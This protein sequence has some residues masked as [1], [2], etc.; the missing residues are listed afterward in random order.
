MLTLK[1]RNDSTG[2][3]KTGNYDCAVTI[4]Q[5]CLWKGRVESFAKSQG[6]VKLLR[7]AI[8]AIDEDQALADYYLVALEEELS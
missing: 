2:T 7:L 8:A 5:H 4:N 6:Y 1:I 3:D